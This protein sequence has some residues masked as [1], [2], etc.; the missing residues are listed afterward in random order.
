MGDKDN[1]FYMNLP[2]KVKA[3]FGFQSSFS[4]QDGA[5]VD[6][7]RYIAYRESGRDGAKNVVKMEKPWRELLTHYD[8]V[9]D[10]ACMI[11]ADKQAAFSGTAPGCRMALK[12]LV[13]SGSADQD[14]LPRIYF[15]FESGNLGDKRLKQVDVVLTYNSENEGGKPI[16]RLMIFR[17][18]GEDVDG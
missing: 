6:A 17:M 10:S 18:K 2:W 16:Y 4:I 9:I 14:Q 13:D 15:V 5:A 1:I 3:G 12:A 8:W 7:E 11:P